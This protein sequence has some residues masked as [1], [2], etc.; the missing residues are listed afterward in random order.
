MARG[1][2]RA[3]AGRPKGSLQNP[4][5]VTTNT[6]TKQPKR[7]QSGDGKKETESLGNKRESKSKRWKGD[8]LRRDPTAAS[9]AD[10]LA[11]TAA[12]DED[13]EIF[14]D[15]GPG[16]AGFEPTTLTNVGQRLTTT[17][18]QGTATTAQTGSTSNPETE[19][20]A[21]FFPFLKPLPT[22]TTAKLN[23]VLIELR[24]RP[25]LAEVFSFLVMFQDELA[26]GTKRAVK[27]LGLRQTHWAARPPTAL[28]LELALADPSGALSL[29]TLQGDENTKR[30]RIAKRNAIVLARTHLSLLFGV[31]PTT[32]VG[33][34]PPVGG[35]SK[36]WPEWLA[37]V[38][39]DRKRAIF[40]KWET[41]AP[42]DVSAFETVVEEDVVVA[43][44]V[45]TV[46]AEE[47]QSN[48]LVTSAKETEETENSDPVVYQKTRRVV[49]RS[50]AEAYISITPT[51][52][53]RALWGLCE[54]R[55]MGDDMRAKAETL[56]GSDRNNLG[57]DDRGDAYVYV[58]GERERGADTTTE[59]DCFGVVGACARVCRAA[60]PRW[61]VYADG[62]DDVAETE[63]ETETKP[64]ERAASPQT[65]PRRD[66]SP[67]ASISPAG[68]PS[69]GTLQYA[70]QLIWADAAAAETDAAER[71]AF[72]LDTSAN[73]D[74]SDDSSD[75]ESD[76]DS[77]PARRKQKQTQKQKL[78]KTGQ[79]QKRPYT[80]RETVEQAFAR[81]ERCVLGD[82]IV[83]LGS[84]GKWAQEKGARERKTKWDK[85]GQSRSDQK[86][87]PSTGEIANARSS[88]VPPYHRF[89]KSF[90]G[91][92]GGAGGS[93]TTDVSDDVPVGDAPATAS[94]ITPIPN[95]PG[96]PLD[97][98]PCAWCGE[99]TD[100]GLFVLCDGC[101]N[102]GHLSCLGLRSVPKNAW[103][104][105]VCADGG[106]TAQQGCCPSTLP[107]ARVVKRR[108]ERET[109]TLSVS[110]SLTS[111]QPLKPPREGVWE[112]LVAEDLFF[113]TDVDVAS[114]TAAR[115][116]PL[117]VSALRVIANKVRSAKSVWGN[118]AK[119]WRDETS[120]S[121]AARRA[122]RDAI[123]ARRRGAGSGDDDESDT[124][125]DESEREKGEGFDS[126]SRGSGDEDGARRTAKMKVDAPK[127]L[128]R[129]DV[130]F[131]SG[132]RK[133]HNATDEKLAGCDV[134]CSQCGEV[135]DTNA[136]SV[137]CDSCPT[138]GHAVC[139]FVCSEADGGDDNVAVAAGPETKETK[140]SKKGDDDAKKHAQCFI[141]AEAEKAKD[142][143]GVVSAGVSKRVPLRPASAAKRWR[144]RVPT[145]V[146]HALQSDDDEAWF[147]ET[148]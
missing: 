117:S 145:R 11:A 127:P 86:A 48:A 94:E 116:V 14:L 45:D 25:E 101:P 9:F 29:E 39:G 51:R 50:A 40:G 20:G 90:V 65:S 27:A 3:G 74:S 42:F 110:R 97:D 130:G 146:R 109:G 142:V 35:W 38:S 140:C 104:C 28:E 32:H 18:Q 111:V 4:K 34:K 83:S 19:A 8:R 132:K 47:H 10:G 73:S 98:I 107:R 33:D 63:T 17:A 148:G 105:A 54:A 78:A 128:A 85:K 68:T 131:R 79:G 139:F 96:V 49:R 120:T 52:R 84:Q 91:G 80:R 123:D 72:V 102:G 115:T 30:T 103:W 100:E 113:H 93:G 67:K 57:T 70:E 6:K 124:S 76:F 119:N 137:R 99:L 23:A 138:E 82:V 1:G 87:V 13:L 69:R 56:S 71:W 88:R 136:P 129:L 112:T 135:C 37:R 7:K 66:Q 89:A 44:V 31:E 133:T 147:F 126:D 106:E 108:R 62:T 134:L 36:R 43:T 92:G 58:G 26:A 22:A 118:A 141:C 75:S 41:H 12:E 2:A 95:D 21:L 77:P 46:A 53:I 144:R 60:P 122:R 5:L 81:R 15:R 121:A 64:P 125:A 55:L 16:A 61:D 143:D 24:C 59:F 114:E